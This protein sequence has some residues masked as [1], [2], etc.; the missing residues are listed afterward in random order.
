MI[1]SGL[2][3]AAVMALATPSTVLAP[4][5]EQPAAA[6]PARQPAGTIDAPVADFP[7]LSPAVASADCGQLLATPAYCL[8]AQLT[9]IGDLAERYIDTLNGVGWL[10]ADGDD[11]RV[12]FVRRKA[13]GIC[14][15]MQMVAFYDE[16]KPVTPTTIGY[17]GFAPIPGNI[18]VAKPAQGPSDQ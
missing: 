7:I 4:A 6:A 5:Q 1:L 13:D 8:S 18:C 11:N 12:I 17:L 2:T 15:G 3:L 16:A 9:E 10:A 14:D